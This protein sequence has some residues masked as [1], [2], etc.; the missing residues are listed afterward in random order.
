MGSEIKF[1]CCGVPLG[2]QLAVRNLFVDFILQ[3]LKGHRVRD[4]NGIFL[5]F[6]GEGILLRPSGRENLV[7]ELFAFQ[8]SCA[9][10]ESI[11]ASSAQT[12]LVC[13]LNS[14]CIIE[15]ERLLAVGFFKF[16]GNSGGARPVVDEIHQPFRRHAVGDGKGGFLAVIGKGKD[17]I[18]AFKSGQPVRSGDAERILRA[19]VLALNLE[20]IAGAVLDHR[21]L[22]AR[23]FG[24]VIDLFGEL[25]QRHVRRNVNGACDALVCI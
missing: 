14:G 11:Q 19:G 24:V 23:I 8:R 7:T 20:H 17:L 1:A 13:D 12:D 16:R 9:V 15:L 6:I 22:D 5:A 10:D 25:F 4:V 21:R 18:R 3:V 2:S